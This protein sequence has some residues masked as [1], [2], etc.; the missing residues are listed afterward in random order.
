MIAIAPTM[1]LI[2]LVEFRN[3]EVC[4]LRSD[5]DEDDD[6]IG[7]YDEEISTMVRAKT[8]FI[9]AG[10]AIT[11]FFLGMAATV[12]LVEIGTRSIGRLK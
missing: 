12:L 8:F 10:H 9:C 11:L 7:A 4:D 6:D 3:A 5:D 1:I 2:L